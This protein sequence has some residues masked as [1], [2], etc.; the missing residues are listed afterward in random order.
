MIGY[1]L[2]VLLDVRFTVVN[3]RTNKSFFRVYSVL[4]TK[5]FESMALD[6]R[7][8]RV[9]YLFAHKISNF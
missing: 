3:K 8:L 9:D 7:R 5:G 2:C 1:L 4:V 6:L